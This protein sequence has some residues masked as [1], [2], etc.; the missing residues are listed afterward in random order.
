MSKIPSPHFQMESWAIVFSISSLI[1]FGIVYI[2]PIYQSLD[3]RICFTILSFFSTQR[4]FHSARNIDFFRFGTHLYMSLFPS[5]RL[6]VCAS[7]C[8]RSYLRN[9]TS[10]SH[11]PWYT[12]VKWWYVLF[13][14]FWKFWLFRLLGCEWGSTKSSPKRK[15]ITSV[16]HHISGAVQHLIMIFGIVV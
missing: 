5:L 16:M 8:C 7:V 2:W 14:F 10:S 13:S 9:N 4:E 1:N 11:H 3:K 6:S 12:R 15:I